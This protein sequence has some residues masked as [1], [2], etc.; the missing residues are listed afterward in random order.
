VTA[1]LRAFIALSGGAVIASAA[2]A[3]AQQPRVARIGFLGL[4]TPMALRF[5]RSKPTR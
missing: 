5:S 3:L 4:T 1:R 2:P